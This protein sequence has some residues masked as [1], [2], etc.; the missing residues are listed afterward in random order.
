MKFKFQITFLFFGSLLFQISFSQHYRDYY[1][2]CYKADSL[3]YEKNYTLALEKYKSAFT[4]VD[5]VHYK[6]LRSA[7]KCAIRI[8][9]FESAG[10]YLRQS[11]INTGF[12][13]F[14]SAFKRVPS[15]RFKRT[16]YYKNIKDSIP[17]YLEQHKKNT[18]WEYSAII[19]SL[20]YVDQRIIRGSKHAKG[21][22]DI[23]TSMLPRNR[24]ELDST[25]FQTLLECIE[26]WGFPSEELV[27]AN[28]IMILHH[29]MRL[30]K[31]E[32]YHPIAFKAVWEGDWDP[33]SF[34]WM[35]EQ[36]CKWHK[37]STFFGLGGDLSEENIKRV[38]EN[39][40]KFYLR[41]L[42]HSNIKAVKP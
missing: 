42:S 15:G 29:N 26:K 40:E 22:Y 10:R 11:I 41:P 28:P 9:D 36:Y 3:I 35:Y 39:R 33:R 6:Y 37:D 19:D 1:K 23:D 30:E 4:S 16:T 27:D 32:K 34:S 5:Y 2:N 25:N 17:H 18:N 20:H 24:Y 21:D 12:V 7:A 8:K 13:D 38:S 31:N 14:F